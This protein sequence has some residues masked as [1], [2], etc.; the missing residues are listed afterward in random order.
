VQTFVA[1]S[2]IE[3][4][5]VLMAICNLQIANNKL[6]EGSRSELMFIYEEPLTERKVS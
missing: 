1:A 5:P 2:K 4:I 6:L 3:I